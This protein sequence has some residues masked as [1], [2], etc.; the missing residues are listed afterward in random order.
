LKEAKKNKELV[1]KLKDEELRLLFNDGISNQ[2]G[3]KKSTAAANA[4]AMGVTE[5]LLDMD[6]LDLGTS[7]DSED[8]SENE[9]QHAFGQGVDYAMEHD[10]IEAVE[11]FKEKTIE[12]IIEE[13]RAKLAADGKKGTPVTEASFTVWLVIVFFLLCIIAILL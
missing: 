9:G 3:K 8:D 4:K 5:Q 6:D 11:I 12:D 13:Q 7:S 2:F 10:D 1:K